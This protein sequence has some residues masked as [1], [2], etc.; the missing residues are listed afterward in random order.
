MMARVDPKI[1]DF[2][3]YGNNTLIVPTDSIFSRNT[4]SQNS[5]L[6]DRTNN[7]CEGFHAKLNRSLN[8][9][10]PSFFEIVDKI[11]KTM[12]CSGTELSRILAGGI[13]KPKKNILTLIT[14]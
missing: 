8:K 12:I 3:D 2:L 13:E 9:S 7:A 6:N 5:S 4:W 10:S 11:K 1:E 14:I